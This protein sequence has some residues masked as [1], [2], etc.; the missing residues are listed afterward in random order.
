MKTDKLKLHEISGSEL[1]ELEMCRVLGG[2]EVGCCQCGCKYANNGGSSTSA[3]NSANNAGG[4]TSDGSQQCC[5]YEGGTIEGGDLWGGK[6]EIDP[7]IA[8][9]DNLCPPR[10]VI[11]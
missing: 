10:P 1:N 4:L 3:N 9:Q 5:K 7:Y 8:E 6:I 11:P 2:G